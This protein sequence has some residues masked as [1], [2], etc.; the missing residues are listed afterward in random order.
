MFIP[1]KVTTDYS[2][3]KS[4]IKVKDLIYFCDTHNIKVCGI[5]D[6]NL[7]SSMEFYNECIKNNIKP[8]I[9]LEVI[10]NNYKL[11][12]YCQNNNGYKNLLKINTSICNNTFNMD[13]FNKYNNDLIV[14]I[15]YESIN[16]YNDIKVSNKYISYKNDFEYSNLRDKYKNIVY[17]NDIR[18]F[19]KEDINYLELL[20][21]INNDEID[22]D[23]SYFI[24]Y[25][26]E[27]NKIDEI[28]ELI[29]IDLSNNNKYIPKY[30]K[31]T[32]SYKYLCELCMKGLNRRLHNNVPKEYLDRLKYELNVINKMGFV[33]YFLIVYDYVLFAKKNGILVGP[34]RGSAAGSL[35]SFVIGITN[36]D[37]IK[38]NLLFER[39]LNPE[40]VS[41]PD[42]D[43]DFDSTR[44]DEVISYV[45]NKYGYDNVSLI[46]T[47]G[48]YKTR[49]VLREVAKYYNV[50]IEKFLKYID[51]DKNL[52][53]NLKNEIIIKFL[54]N[55]P[56]IKKVYNLSMRFEGLKKNISTHAA[57]IVIGD[58]C[59]DEIIPMYKN[60]EV[61]L[62]GIPKEY[63][64]DIGLL[65]MDF[66]ALKNLNMISNIINK[67]D[68]FNI[69]NI[70]LEEKKVYEL[71]CKGDTDGIFQFE[72]N[73]F[74]KMLPLY[75]PN[76]FNELV[77]SIAL[78]RPGPKMELDTYIKRKEGREVVN[79]YDESLKP[80]LEETYGVIV[81]QEQVIN[82]L[83]KMAG[84]S[85][86]EA[87]NIRRAMAKKKMNIIMETK[88]KFISRCIKNNY[89]KELA[90]NI[91]EHILSFA[92]YGFNKAHSV[93]YA[94]V[95]YQMAYLKVHYH[96]L[97]MFELLNESLGSEEVPT[98]LNEL[99]KDYE[100]MKPDIN[101]S[102]NEFV[103][104]D[105]KLYLPFKMIKNIKIDLINNIINERNNGI[106]IDIYDFF[107]RCNKFMNKKDYIL[108]INS[109]VL[110][111]NFN[112]NTLINN[113]DEL[114]N[115][116]ELAN[117]MDNIYKPNID[118]KDEVSD[119]ILRSNE[120][121]SY[122]FYVTNHP[123]C[124]Y[125]DKNI[126][127]I[128][129]IN[130]YLF[131]NI[132]MIVLIDS[133]KKIKTKNNDDMAFVNVS[134]ETGV[135]STVIFKECINLINDLKSNDLVKIYGNVSKRYDK[136]NIVIKN[137]MKV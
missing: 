54:N 46:M 87:D 62:T 82:I 70:D 35:V 68:N 71:F 34:G 25:N 20:S 77:A 38:Y 110:S 98:Y 92:D 39:F 101:I 137:I 11:Y 31:D 48:T 106:F 3:H 97:F 94:L 95:S 119:D 129:D 27:I 123:S 19:K 96:N 67:I 32:D 99:K 66:L 1:I 42:I 136:I 59:L 37:P 120:I 24:K 13:I 43:I 56:D 114:I 57:G 14:I 131:K 78:V 121:N 9:G 113:L 85:Y 81:Y 61:Y 41:M 90:L 84:F 44:R 29:N 108:L 127:K 26:Y 5:C 79:Y 128:K 135:Y 102:T 64:E 65:K 28:N 23:I 49:L 69:N 112:Y 73:T 134:D 75:K 125:N 76:N 53:D 105:N 63:L 50:D 6:I 111:F 12:L 86:A 118:I 115:Y 15:P 2:L 88:E 72:T 117:E 52:K 133:I 124:K 16:I 4:L 55:Y 17:L 107:K 36:I 21:V 80:I 22:K 93:S 74:K 60:E 8:I 18:A 132:M 10:L 130:N 104:K 30:N 100:I 109:G 40:R 83:V 51:K 116:G 45:K 91:Y 122:G 89:S 103:I 47:Y 126:V 7:F 58:R 33:D